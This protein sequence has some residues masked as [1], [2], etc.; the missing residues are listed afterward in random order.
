[1]LPSSKELAETPVQSFIDKLIVLNSMGVPEGANIQIHTSRHFGSSG[2]WEVSLA[3][4]NGK[5][6]HC[7]LRI[8]FCEEKTI[9]YGV[10]D[11]NRCTVPGQG[12]PNPLWSAQGNKR[13]II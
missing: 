4:Q 9:D 7:T 13:E 12:G 11:N 6:P 10:I 1:M 8:N 5:R 3:K 2:K